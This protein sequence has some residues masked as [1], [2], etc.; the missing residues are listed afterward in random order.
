[1]KI[2]KTNILMDFFSLVFG[3]MTFICCFFEMK[4][5]IYIK[6]KV[7]KYIIGSDFEPIVNI[8]I[9]RS[10]CETENGFY[11]ILNYKF[12]GIDEN[13]YD[14]KSKKFL[15]ES[16]TNSDNFKMVNQINERTIN[17]WREGNVCAKKV[18]NNTDDYVFYFESINNNNK[19]EKD[20]EDKTY[21]GYLNNFRDEIKN[22]SLKIKVYVKG[23]NNESYCPINF[24]NIY[25]SNENEIEFGNDNNNITA[26]YE[27][28]DG[29]VL[30]YSKDNKEGNI[31]TDLIISEDFPCLEKERK[32]NKTP[33]FPML[34]DIKNFKCNRYRDSYYDY[35][36]KKENITYAFDKRFVLIDNISKYQLFKDNGFDILYNSLPYINSSNWKNDLNSSDFGLY[37]RSFYLN[38]DNYSEFN[39]YHHSIK[40]LFNLHYARL[41]I[42]IGNLLILIFF[43]VILGLIK[44]VLA[45][46]HTLIFVLKLVILILIFIINIIII[47]YSKNLMS[48]DVKYFINKDNCFDYN[49]DKCPFD[50]LSTKLIKRYNLYKMIDSYDIIIKYEIKFWWCFFSFN[51]IQAFRLI[52]KIYIRIKNKKRRQI[53]K[54]EIGKYNLKNIMKEFREKKKN[55][56]K[57]QNLDNSDFL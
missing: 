40:K 36:F 34:N 30:N 3:F 17:I 27:F 1:M 11:P 43:I 12:K 49:N 18:K 56:K 33:Q 48:D 57:Q 19:N 6:D 38:K 20:N 29:Y 42:N 26:N 39:D 10:R 46:C 2:N 21:C 15:N 32:S 8:T 28:L 4:S 53:V 14:V 50:F 41:C 44:F 37:Y 22:E 7:E 47:G 24:I 52:Y 25:N 35:D 13:C 31:L 55:K 16:C 45:I 51:L 9:S 23:K 54:E 5:V